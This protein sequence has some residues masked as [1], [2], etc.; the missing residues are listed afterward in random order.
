MDCLQRS[1]RM[2]MF[3]DFVFQRATWPKVSSMPIQPFILSRVWNDITQHNILV[4]L[5]A[6]TCFSCTSTKYDPYLSQTA[7]SRFSAFPWSGVRFWSLSL[8]FPI[9]Q[10]QRTN[11]QIS[12]DKLMVRRRFLVLPV[13]CVVP[14]FARGLTSLFFA[15]FVRYMSFFFT[16]T[17]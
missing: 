8:N 10:I 3:A 13:M 15:F 4:V 11:F 1:M 12:W 14:Y 7:G 9:F 17:K 6:W 5:H 2:D 16:E